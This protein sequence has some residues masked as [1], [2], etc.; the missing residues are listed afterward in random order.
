[1]KRDGV[2]QDKYVLCVHNYYMYLNLGPHAILWSSVPDPSQLCFQFRV[3]TL[4]ASTTSQNQFH[5]R[6]FDWFQTCLTPIMVSMY[7]DVSP[8]GRQ[9]RQRYQLIRL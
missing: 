9:E 1:M 8:S 4:T 5:S 2:Q 6:L 3:Q 7:L